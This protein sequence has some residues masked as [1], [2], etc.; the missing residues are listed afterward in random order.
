ML[1][2][3]TKTS[4]IQHPAH[5]KRW[6]PYIS[7]S[8]VIHFLLVGLYETEP[9][10]SQ[11]IPST[12]TL[13]VTFLPIPQRQPKPQKLAVPSRE[14]PP[15]QPKSH[16]E[17]Q[18]IQPAPT[19]A[20]VI[21]D[22]P[23]EELQ[24]SI[25]FEKSTEPEKWFKTLKTFPA[26]SNNNSSAN[27]TAKKNLADLAHRLT[28]LNKPEN[29]KDFGLTEHVLETAKDGAAFYA[30]T[31]SGN[32]PAM[33]AVAGLSMHSGAL[34]H[35]FQKLKQKLKSPTKLND[36]E[37]ALLAQL[38]EMAPVTVR[39]LYLATPSGWTYK[40]L[41]QKLEDWA[42]QNILM[43]QGKGHTARYSLR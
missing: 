15:A 43:R 18:P 6:M 21:S 17:E 20:H 27:E 7:A 42:G 12:P 31:S 3:P 11:L 2:C 14:L 23:A 30:A 22:P 37:S 41:K 35:N 29:Q 33:I 34:R 13:T 28:Q 32:L 25:M 40:Q 5:L 4:L 26:G 36:Q 1:T 39:D 9:Q 10:H 24:K 38:A 16:S 19:Q 8:L